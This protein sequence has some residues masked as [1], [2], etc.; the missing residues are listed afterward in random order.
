MEK[1]EQQRSRVNHS[2]SLC[3]RASSSYED[4]GNEGS[5]G[6]LESFSSNLCLYSSKICRAF[7]RL[8]AVSLEDFC[9]VSASCITAGGIALLSTDNKMVA[10]AL[11]KMLKKDG[12]LCMSAESELKSS[13]RCITSIFSSGGRASMVV[14]R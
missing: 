8:G 1:V 13:K 12:I 5:R 14:R 9:A 11:L 7:S 6:A 2:I 3:V 4:N 10:F